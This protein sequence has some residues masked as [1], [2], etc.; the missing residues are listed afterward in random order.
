MRENLVHT[1]KHEVSIIFNICSACSSITFG[2]LL[3]PVRK[4][5]ASRKYM[6]G[7]FIGNIF[8]NA[9]PSFIGLVGLVLQGSPPM[10]K[11]GQVSCICI[12]FGK[13]LFFN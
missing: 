8:L 2:Q 10:A 12:S 1:R 6:S 9:L 11:I 13:L 5:K 7:L 3:K 4:A